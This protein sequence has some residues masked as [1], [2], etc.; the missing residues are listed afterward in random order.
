MIDPNDLPPPKFPDEG[1]V[2][3]APPIQPAT[4]EPAPEPVVP[5]PDDEPEPVPVIPEYEAFHYLF[6]KD[7]RIVE[8]GTCF[9]EGIEMLKGDK[10]VL[11][12]DRPL[13]ADEQREM[14][15]L[16]GELTPKLEFAVEPSYSIQVGQE[17]SISV[18]AGTSV[19]FEGQTMLI[20]DGLLELEADHVMTYNITLSHPIYLARTIEISV[21][22]A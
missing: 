16:N 8:S 22:E 21:H 11:L 5:L 1:E 7:G 13:S 6:H 12:L 3:V 10:E 17:T 20:E 9:L 14:Y 18:P 2:P 4:P 19:T 15:V